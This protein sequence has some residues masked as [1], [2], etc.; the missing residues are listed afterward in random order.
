MRDANTRYLSRT[1]LAYTVR[2]LASVYEPDDDDATQ[3]DTFSTLFAPNG[4]AI[5]RA[6]MKTGGEF[7]IGAIIAKKSL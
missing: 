6:T 1:A 2:R 3:D 4:A 5:G 7:N